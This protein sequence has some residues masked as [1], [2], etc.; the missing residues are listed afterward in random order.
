[1]PELPDFNKY[2]KIADKVVAK[3]D[4]SSIEEGYRELYKELKKDGWGVP[5]YRHFRE[6]AIEVAK[7]RPLH[8]SHHGL[9]DEENEMARLIEV[10]HKHGWREGQSPDHGVADWET[11]KVQKYKDGLSRSLEE[12]YGEYMPELSTND[13][14][15]HHLNG[16]T[17]ISFRGSRGIHRVGK[18][19]AARLDWL[20]N[21]TPQKWVEQLRLR[22]KTDADLEK[23][24]QRFGPW[25]K[26]KYHFTGYSKGGGDRSGAIHYGEKYGVNTTTINPYI[27][28]DI[29]LKKVKMEHNIIRT[30]SDIASISG[31]A[32][33]RNTKKIKVKSVPPLDK[34]TTAVGEH[35]LDNF[36]DHMTD[37][38]RVGQRA[39]I[40]K[41][42]A[43]YHAVNT[44]KKIKNQL[45]EVEKALAYK[46]SSLTKYLQSFPGSQNADT[47]GGLPGSSTAPDQPGPSQLPNPTN[48]APDIT[49]R[50]PAVDQRVSGGTGNDRIISQMSRNVRGKQRMTPQQIAEEERLSRLARARAMAMGSGQQAPGAI[51]VGD[52]VNLVDNRGPA[53]P[54]ATVRPQ[55]MPQARTSSSAGIVRHQGLTGAGQ[56]QRRVQMG[57]DVGGI[58]GPDVR[59]GPFAPKV[60]AEAEENLKRRLAKLLQSYVDESGDDALN[61]DTKEFRERYGRGVTKKSLGERQKL[62][63]EGKPIPQRTPGIWQKLKK[64]EDDFQAKYG[65]EKTQLLMRRIMDKEKLV[66]L[67]TGESKLDEDTLEHIA[68]EKQ[69]EIEKFL[70][71]KPSDP[72]ITDLENRQETSADPVRSSRTSAWLAVNNGPAGITPEEARNLMSGG[73]DVGSFDSTLT[74]DELQRY[75]RMPPNQRK[76]IQ[77]H[78]TNKIAS[79]TA[80]MDSD[81]AQPQLRGFRAGLGKLAGGRSLLATKSGIM[82]MGVGAGVQELM[83]LAGGDNM[84]EYEE[85]AI[86]GGISGAMVERGAMWLAGD[87]VKTLADAGRIAGSAIEGAGGVVVGDFATNAISKAFGKNAN[88]YERDIISNVAGGEIG[89]AAGV[90]I[91]G[92]GIA[93]TGF[94]AAG[95]EGAAA[96]LNAWNPVGWGL[97]AVAAVTALVGL[98]AGIFEAGAEEKA[99]KEKKLEQKELKYAGQSDVLKSQ[100]SYVRTYLSE[101]G[102]NPA[103]L[104]QMDQELGMKLKSEDVKSLTTKQMSDLLQTYIKNFQL[105]DGTFADGDQT[106]AQMFRQEETHAFQSGMGTLDS[107][108]SALKKAGAKNVKVPKVSINDPTG[109]QTAYNALL[110]GNQAT[111]TKLGL[112]PL[113]VEGATSTG[114]A[115][116]YT[117]DIPHAWHK[118]KDQ[119]NSWESQITTLGEAHSLRKGNYESVWKGLIQ[120]QPEMAGVYNQFIKAEGG[121]EVKTSAGKS[122]PDLDNATRLKYISQWEQIAKTNPALSNVMQSFI[123][124]ANDYGGKLKPPPKKPPPVPTPGTGGTPTPG[125][126]G[127]GGG[128]GPSPTKAVQP[129]PKFADSKSQVVAH[130]KA[131]QP[132]QGV[133]KIMPSRFA[134][135]K[136]QAA[137]PPMKSNSSVPVAG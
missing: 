64:M 93:A 131:I 41:S 40:P 108:A 109:Y 27:S 105:D 6:W 106:G 132:P 38:D 82:G 124:A 13:F 136:S 99:K 91:T 74:M 122:T 53:L 113:A 59:S 5:A 126:G 50:Q 2:K 111:A 133:N 23:V 76:A 32:K 112:K 61:K 115:Y 1:M 110:S 62:L 119:I 96:A 90:G 26:D 67:N 80:A 125:T 19:S 79:T 60:P 3:Y 114:A 71:V 12:K 8:A 116:S 18:S 36:T 78:Y 4:D 85:G 11:K 101:M 42:Y 103:L 48:A 77:D 97:A 66:R 65:V 73:I 52:L 117:T 88:P 10:L 100:Y 47:M 55:D 22:D 94:A 129:P 28:G 37:G 127:T 14:S 57:Q 107:L 135:S 25:D 98:F 86:S 72:G 35:E 121:K 120:Q 9:T 51:N 20:E 54:A 29:N 130:T 69:L 104:A 63:D 68:A 7:N 39:L 89:L 134:D 92:L 16:K 81:F 137:T 102:M 33:P 17:T 45:D 46:N 21:M 44:M 95:A 118:D 84:N 123:S 87:G 15:V 31:L 75:S 49:N 70:G 43:R 83:T 58:P 24:A 128:P 34:Y 30:P 56:M